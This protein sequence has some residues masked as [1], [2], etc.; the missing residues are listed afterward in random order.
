MKNMFYLQ[1]TTSLILCLLLLWQTTAYSQTEAPEPLR[2][3]DAYIEKAMSDWQIPGLAIAVVKDDKIIYAKG[4]GVQEIGKNETVNE[5]T[6]FP[7]AS[8]TKAFTAAALGILADEGKLKIDD[9]ITKFLPEFQLYDPFVTKEITIRDLLAHKTGLADADILRFGDYDRAEILRRARFLPPSG[10]FRSQF[11]YNNQMYLAAGQIIPAITQKSWDLF[12]K[13]RIFTPLGMTATGTSVKELENNPNAA[14][15][16]AKISGK[17]QAIPYLSVD[18][19]A[20]SGAIN[21]NVVDM[22]QWLRLQLGK[23]AVGGQQI[24]SSAIIKEMHS[25]QITIPY[26]TLEN[27]IYGEPQFLTY[28]LGW[29]VQDYRGKK[30]VQHG[31]RHP[32]MTAQVG[33]MPEENLGVV[34]L[35]NMDALP[36]RAALMFRVFDAFLGGESKDRSAELLSIFKTGEQQKETLLKQLDEKLAQAPKPPL[37]LSE[38]TGI[39]EEPMLG[40]VRVM[41]EKEKLVLRYSAGMSGDLAHLGNN[42]FIVT[43]RNSVYDKAQVGFTVNAN[44]KVEEIKL[45]GFTLKRAI[46][47]AKSEISTVPTVT[48][49]VKWNLTADVGGQ[50]IPITLELKQEGEVLNGSL[51]SPIGTGTVKNAQITGNLFAGAANVNFQGQQMEIALKGT[52]DSGKMTGTISGPGLPA[53]SFTGIRGN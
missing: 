13:E 2:N 32:G 4:F 47:V 17:V 37:D 48:P 53:I 12:L 40:Q 44:G 34:I 38:Y 7:I 9:K 14:R 41:R 42:N 15:P 29:Y 20:P 18:N 19:S 46:Q 11:S 28:G 10:S 21:S 27:K 23:G 30:V 5:K 39:Y 26:K 49:T 31:G 45:M 22:A 1:R 3:I 52:I 16:H 35:T 25:P 43:W 24:L 8:A 51:S 50:K 6:V 33:F 36:V